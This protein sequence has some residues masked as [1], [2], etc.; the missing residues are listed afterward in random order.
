MWYNVPGIQNTSEL[1]DTPSETS[2]LLSPGD[3]LNN[4]QL[5]KMNLS[6]TEGASGNSTF[7][8]QTTFCMVVPEGNV[9][10]YL[11]TVGS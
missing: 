9:L 2:S 1:D 8:C 11:R 5:L 3:A 7:D 10:L 4:G 6:C